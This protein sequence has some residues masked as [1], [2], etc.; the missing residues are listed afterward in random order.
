MRNDNGL[1]LVPLTVPATIGFELKVHILS[2]LK[3]IPFSGKDYE[4]SFN[5]INEVLEIANYFNV[6]NV[7]RDVLL[8]M[9]CMTFT[10]DAKIWLKLLAPRTSRT[11]D[12]LC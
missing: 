4:D 11:W 7:T 12:N 9:I 3:D 5:H 2:T 1:G 8:R 10:R 6:P